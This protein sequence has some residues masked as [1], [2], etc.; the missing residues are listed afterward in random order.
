MAD[1]LKK[2]TLRH[3]RSL[4]ENGGW[5]LVSK[6]ALAVIL[7]KNRPKNVIASNEAG[8]HKCMQEAQ[9]RREA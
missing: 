3:N 7:S 5:G 6:N 2:A 1:S 9:V 4:L 8:T